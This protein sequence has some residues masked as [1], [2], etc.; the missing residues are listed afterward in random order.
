[1]TLFQLYQL[2]LGWFL[3]L[4]ILWICESW[5]DVVMRW[6]SRR[7]ILNAILPHNSESMGCLRGWVQGAVWWVHSHRDFVNKVLG[8]YNFCN[9]MAKSAQK[10][11]IFGRSLQRVSIF[12][13]CQCLNDLNGNV[14][15]YNLIINNGSHFLSCHRHNLIPSI[16]AFPWLPKTAVIVAFTLW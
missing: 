2:V 4:Q 10:K 9:F 15:I 11:H 8:L 14:I 13:L 6:V 16:S 3:T 1:M 7:W 12:K 5:P